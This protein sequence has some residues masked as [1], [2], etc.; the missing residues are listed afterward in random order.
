MTLIASD[1]FGTSTALSADGTVLA[2]GVIGSS[3]TKGRKGEM[4]IFEKTGRRRGSQ[5]LKIFDKATAAGAGELDIP[6]SRNDRFG[7]SAAISADGTGLVVGAEDGSSYKGAVYF[8]E[9]TGGTWS[10][11]MNI[12]DNNGGTGSIPLTLENNDDFGTSVA[13]S[14]DGTLL[15]VGA[16]SDDDGGRQQ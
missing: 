14:M 15:A 1:N 13:L 9:K 12:S 7:S 8:F 3:S 6:L 10:R 16:R 4:Y 5:S 11:T 2:V